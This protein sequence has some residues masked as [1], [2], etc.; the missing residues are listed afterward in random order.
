V[1]RR[2]FIASTL[3][4]LSAPLAAQGQPATKVPRIGVLRLGPLPP[5]ALEAFRQGLR[6]RGYLPQRPDAPLPGQGLPGTESGAP[7]RLGQNR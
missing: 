3:G 5:S 6:E 1:D 2:A 4:L 7:S